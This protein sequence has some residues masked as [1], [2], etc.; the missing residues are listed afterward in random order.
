MLSAT[1]LTVAGQ[2]Q[3]SDGLGRIAVGIIDTLKDDVSINFICLINE[4]FKDISKELEKFVCDAKDKPP[5]NVCILTIPP[6]WAPTIFFSPIPDC[7]IY[8]A[9]SM[10]ESTK[11]P[12]EWVDTFNNNFDAVIVPDPSLIKVYEN[13]GV[14]IP[15]FSLPLGMY[16]S[17]FF[18]I[19]H[20]KIPHSPFVFGSTATYIPRKN[21]PTLIQAF[22]EEFGES[23]AVLLSLH[24]RYKVDF[25]IN[26]ILL[27]SENI[28]ISDAVLSHYDYVKLM[29]SFDC[30]INI[31]KGEGFSCGPREALAMGIPCIISDNTA[32]HTICNSGYVRRVPSK[33]K[34]RA[35]CL[36]PI[37]DK[38]DLG[39]QFNCNVEDVRKALRDVYE[40]YSLYNELAQTG[41]KWVSKYTWK[42]LKE[43]Y[44]NLVK[45]KKIILGSENKITNDY[46]MTNS[47]QLYSKY[48]KLKKMK[49]TAVGKFN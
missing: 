20:S 42:N 2:F 12:F 37:Y 14:K 28:K 17:D 9:Y 43:K 25:F 13:S 36:N 6:A 46:L 35:F 26:S 47:Q 15:I 4:S 1:Q 23:K 39:Y 41:K 29:R 3:Q 40:N 5:G 49:K 33:I 7:M 27:N 18:N 24:G 34:E 19:K 45:P 10:F 22:K 32:H 38:S 21:I 44:L 8:F 48:K 11:I 16:L 31:S 30:Y